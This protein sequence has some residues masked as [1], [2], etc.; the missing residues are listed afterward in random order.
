MKITIELDTKKDRNDYKALLFGSEALAALAEIVDL[1][2]DYYH[3]P[4]DNPEFTIGLA[5]FKIE[6]IIKS[7]NIDLE[8][9]NLN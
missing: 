1:L 5:R 7:H 2:Y 6:E 3:H 9:V 4:E 8:E